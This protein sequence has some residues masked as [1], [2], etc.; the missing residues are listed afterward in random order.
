LYWWESKGIF[1][2]RLD[3]GTWRVLLPIGSAYGAGNGGRATAHACIM[4][5]YS[6][7]SGFI[8]SPKIN[9]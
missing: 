3:I 1:D 6:N 8:E 2:F 9:H 5:L 7:K 4:R